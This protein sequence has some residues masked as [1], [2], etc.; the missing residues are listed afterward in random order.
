MSLRID[1]TKYPFNMKIRHHVSTNNYLPAEELK[2]LPE[3][4]PEVIKSI[5]W[6]TIFA[7][8]QSP[9]ELDVGCAKG[10]F[11]LSRAA[12]LKDKNILGLEVRPEPVEW[13]N[14]VIEGEG[15]TN[16][17][18]LHYSVANSLPFIENNS[19]ERIYYLFPDPWVK[20]KHYKR[21]AFT[22]AFLAE[23]HRVLKPDGK[24]YLATDVTEVHDY[25]NNLL[26]KIGLYTS[27][28][29]ESR[30]G[31]DLPVTNKERF[32]LRKNIYVYRTICVKH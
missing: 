30:E 9:A 28:I 15:I 18:A 29:L 4:Y 23:C 2:F 10:L 19:I 3:S 24:L 25:Q 1:F 5:E 8:G 17:K 13:L 7:D 20:R 11:L 32:C 16:C 22:K 26:T 27:T 14:K 6:S 21:R 12:E 31:W